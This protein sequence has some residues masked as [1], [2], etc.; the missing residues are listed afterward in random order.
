MW[1][2]KRNDTNVL[3]YKT[4][5]DSQTYGCQKEGIVRGVGKVMYTLLYW[6]WITNKDLLYST[7]NSPQCYV[8]A[9]MGGKFGGEWIHTHT[10][11]HTHMAES[12]RCTP[13]TT[14]ILFIGYTPIQNNKFKVRK[15]TEFSSEDN[16]ENNFVIIL[17]KKKFFSF[18]QQ[19]PQQT[20]SWLL[21]LE[22]GIKNFYWYSYHSLSSW[23]NSPGLPYL[24]PIRKS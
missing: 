7:G 20:L 19:T 6:K 11:T 1:N 15:K 2:L 18:P 5:R 17:Y 10:H 9:W 12:L 14:T 24:T 3:T 16:N 4:E 21:G 22:K 13:E 23:S 8:A